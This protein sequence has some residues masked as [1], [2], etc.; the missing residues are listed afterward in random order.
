MRA[1]VL[2]AGAIM[3]AEVGDPEPGPGELLVRPRAA[4]ICG[5]DLTAIRDAATLSEAGRRS[6]AFF[7]FHPDDR[8][9]LGHEFMSEVVACGPETTGR[10]APG[11]R[12][13]SVPSLP[14]G[15][16]TELIGFSP[17]APGGFAPLALVAESFTY[18]VA[19]TV[20]DE[21]AAL[22]EPLAVAGHAVDRGE[23][24]DDSAALIVGAG[25]VGL[26]VLAWMVARGIGPVVVSEPNPTRRTL[27]SRLGAAVAVDP[28]VDDPV[29]VWHDLA[30]GRRAVIYECTGKHG[31]LDRL[32]TMAPR[33]A[34]IVVPGMSVTTEQLDPMTA[35][36]KELTIAWSAGYH[37]R[38][39]RDTIAAL[40]DGRLDVDGL[41]TT[42]VG[43]NHVADAVAALE[44]GGDHGKIVVVPGDAPLGPWEGSASG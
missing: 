42:R 17:V 12:V 26:A 23:F 24:D 3:L 13:V 30:P 27:A 41:V 43:A 28:T 19:D 6:G 15:D 14:R 32:V 39:F 35:F 25:P 4:G 16:R 18:P 36:G 22:T 37:A 2:H 8:F 29:A 21:V 31:M 34:R 7:D 33:S 1:P 20:P 11:D 9:V 5:T 38:E 10:F 40:G 44:A